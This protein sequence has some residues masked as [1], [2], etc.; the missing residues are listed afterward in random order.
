MANLDQAVRYT[1]L[2]QDV[3]MSYALQQLK[4]NPQALQRYLQESQDKLF[5]DVTGKKDETF[6]KVYGDLE[7]ASDTGR[8][9]YYYHQRND[10]LNKLQEQVYNSQK[11]SADAVVHDRDL[12]KRQY[13]INQWSGSNKMDTLF[14]YSQLFI[15][16][17]TISL[18]GFVWM[19]GI[20]PTI[21]VLVISLIITIIFI[22]TVVNR[23]QFTNELR[24]G[25]Y[26]NRRKFPVYNPVPTP[27]ICDSGL[28]KSI[29][30]TLTGI[31]SSAFSAFNSA[32]LSLQSGIGQGAAALQTGLASMSAP[33]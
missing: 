22:F 24:D 12:A 1:Q 30:S 27:N 4:D 18:L 14:I 28:K 20:L 6:Q 21:S 17:C 7:R 5:K 15:I 16:L 11:G 23:S 8:A 32:S 26:W 25:R 33:R 9:V 2:F 3:E 13:E 31:E 10:D 19:R 29:E